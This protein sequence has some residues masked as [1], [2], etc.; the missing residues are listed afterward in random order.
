MSEINLIAIDLAKNTF[1]LRAVTHTGKALINRKIF[2]T[3]LM[4]EVESF[5]KSAS[6]AMEACATSHYWGRRF[7]QAGYKVRLIAAQHVKPFVRKQKNDR[8]DAEGIAEA[9]S[10]ESMRFVPIKSVA[11]Q[12]VQSIHR[13]RERYLKTRTALMNEL[14]GLLMEYGI[15]IPK[16]RAPLGEAIPLIPD[17]P[18]VSAVMKELTQELW[19]E[20]LEIEKRLNTITK[21][22]EAQVN[23][24]DI[25]KR[26]MSIPGIAEIGASALFAAVGHMNFKNGRELAAFLGLVPRQN[27]TGGKERLGR[28]SKN[29]DRYIRKLLVHGAR[30]VLYNAH[31]REDR[32]SSWAKVIRDKKGY[33]KGAVAVA[34]R[35]AR[36][37][38]AI[39][40]SDSVFRYDFNPATQSA[41]TLEQSYDC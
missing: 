41:R 13:V 27:S 32:Y 19:L 31:R 8:N 22:I 3:E 18:H 40:S 20:L 17:N 6:I 21:R 28:I 14:R 36:I 2:R 4:K 39:M 26:L 12:D 11:Q 16:G 25:C 35:N 34:N 9:A 1:H 33:T 38:W 15:A 5:P 29:G 24:N 23:S 7:E 10:R 37:A 30:S